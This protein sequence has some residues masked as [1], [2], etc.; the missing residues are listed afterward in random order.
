M[1]DKKKNNSYQHER[2]NNFLLRSP[3]SICTCVWTH[4]V[5]EIKSS[6]QGYDRQ[7]NKMYTYIKNHTSFATL[8]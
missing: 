8:S 4:C 5:G 1:S 2:D 6:Y 7:L 3:F